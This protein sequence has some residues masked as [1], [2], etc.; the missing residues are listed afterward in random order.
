[1][2]AFRSLGIGGGKTLAIAGCL[3]SAMASAESISLSVTVP[4]LEV[5]PYHRPYVAVWLET[6]QRKGVEVISVWYEQDEWLKDLRQW[7]RKLGR[8]DATAYQGVTGAT[9][10][11][12]TYTY[13]WQVPEGITAGDYVLCF[14]ASRE[15]GGRD[16]LR[17][18]VYLGAG[19]PQAY[20]LTGNYEFGEIAISIQP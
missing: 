6:P 9:R 2:S 18:T 14:E 16:F 8:A 4:E 19:T 7:W 5:D 10:K 1:M 20:Q 12:G 11:P 13:E 3:I 15:A 17:Q